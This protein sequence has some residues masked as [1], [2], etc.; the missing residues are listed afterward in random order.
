VWTECHFYTVI[1]R[2]NPDT[3][4]SRTAMDAQPGGD[5]HPAAVDGLP[6]RRGSRVGCGPAQKPGKVG[7]G[8][9]RVGY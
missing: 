3:F 1:V 2:T 5:G 9:I 7:D 4:R 8:G 6:H